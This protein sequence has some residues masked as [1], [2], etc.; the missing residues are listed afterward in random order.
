MNIQDLENQRKNAI[1]YSQTLVKWYF[2]FIILITLLIV[3]LSFDLVLSSEEAIRIVI[4]SYIIGILVIVKASSAKFS[5]FKLNYKRVVISNLINKISPNSLYGPK[6]SINVDVVLESRLVLQEY[7]EFTGEDHIIFDTY[8]NLQICETKMTKRVNKDYYI[9]MLNGLF[10]YATFPFSFE[11]ITIL[12]PKNH[13]IQTFAGEEVRLESPRFMEIWDIQTDNQLGARLALN[14]D[15][16]DN[17]LKLNDTLKISMSM[18]FIDNKLYFTT[19]QDLFKKQSTFL[20][21]DPYVSIYNNDNIQK[22]S[23]ELTIIH[24]IV[25]TFKLRQSK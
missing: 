13:F 11:G 1:T 7:T 22:F 25:Q 14:T 3:W 4:I 24:D 17:L 9:T 23:K 21:P 12:R 20:E 15:I 8:G 5:E 6:E 19:H 2:I 18:S 10:A 16:M